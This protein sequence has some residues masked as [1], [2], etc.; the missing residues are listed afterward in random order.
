[1]VFR[2][3]W[4][5][6]V[7]Q[8]NILPGLSR[9]RSKIGIEGALDLAHQIEA[10]VAHLL[11]EPR[12]L[13]QA[14][15]VLAGD[16]AA[17][18]EGARHDLLE[19]VVH[20]LHLVGVALVGEERRVQVAVAHVAERA[21]LQP[22]ARGRLGDEAHHGASS[23]RGTVTSSRIVVGRTPR[24]RRERVPARGGQLQRLGI[25]ARR[26]DLACAVLPRERRH[27][28][29]LLGDDGRV[30]VGLHQQHGLAVGGQ[31]DVRVLLDAGGRGAGRG[32]RA[33]RE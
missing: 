21:D 3:G 29:G 19:R 25:V 33:C 18:L 31:A 7:G 6:A 30:A 4:P 9:P 22:V 23:L 14:D 5:W 26:A 24:Q 8:S 27:A 11:P 17:E 20:A 12:L 16:G 1:M 28:R 32:T 13:G 15:A 10:R 2:V